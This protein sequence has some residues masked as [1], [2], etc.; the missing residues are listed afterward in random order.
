MGPMRSAASL[1]CS[2]AVLT[3]VAA[4]TTACAND[5]PDSDIA[6]ANRSVVP[7]VSQR[8]E[9]PNHAHG[10]G[11]IVGRGMVITAGHIVEGDLRSLA[12]D[13]QPATVVALDRN[14][15]LAI[16]AADLPATEPLGFSALRPPDLVLL[17]PDGPQR[18]RVQ[19]RETLVIEHA[20]DHATYRRAIIVF[21][22]GVV[23]GMSGSPVVDQQGR[24]A[25]AVD[26]SE[27]SALLDAASTS[28]TPEPTAT[29]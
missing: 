19:G 13:G 21:T 9:N 20:T 28:D 12:V 27:I 10:Q 26:A 16:V 3:G 22:P 15:D 2:A 8:C 25:G 24:L 17:G 14:T 5:G 1:C 18:V 11:V 4:L 23:E 7:I 6:R 29:C